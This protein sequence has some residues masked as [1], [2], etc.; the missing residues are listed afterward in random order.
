M[1]RAWSPPFTA[2]VR[3]WWDSAGGVEHRHFGRTLVPISLMAR[4]K[5]HLWD[6]K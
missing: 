2:I 6:W 1:I 3:D 5:A 4:F